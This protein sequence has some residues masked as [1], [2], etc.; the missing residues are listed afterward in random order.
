MHAGKSIA[1]GATEHPEPAV[2][3]QP[4][5]YQH[6]VYLLVQQVGMTEY[7]GRIQDDNEA[8]MYRDAIKMAKVRGKKG[9]DQ[10][11]DGYPADPVSQRATR[12]RIFEA[13]VNL[14]GEQDRVSVDGIL[15]ESLAVKEV[16]SVSPLEIELVV[17]DLMVCLTGLVTI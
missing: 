3:G 15:L 6:E 4:L 1:A 7:T 8:L 12:K 16:R 9:Y 5:D 11:C 14:G 10:K 13:I 2:R 17:H